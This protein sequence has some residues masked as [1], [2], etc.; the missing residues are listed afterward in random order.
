MRITNLPTLAAS[1]ALAFLLTPAPAVGQSRSDD[2]D[3]DRERR[4]SRTQS[5][6]TRAIVRAIEEAYKAP[7]EVHEEVLDELRDQ[8]RR[9]SS[10]REEEIIE[11]VRRM[12]RTTP[13][14]EEEILRELRTAYQLRSPKGEERVFAVIRK[15]K[16]MPPGT[17]HPVVRAELTERTFRRADR[18]DD[19][20]V[21]YDEMSEIL[22]GQWVRWDRN[23]DWAIDGEE[24]GRFFRAHHKEVSTAV[25][26]GK[27]SL[28]LPKGVAGP[29]GKSPT[30]WFAEY[31]TDGDGQVGLY[32]WRRMEQPIEEFVPMDGNGDG[33]LTARELLSY[34]EETRPPAEAKK[35]P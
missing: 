12:Y 7:L 15:N 30:G 19:E 9:P 6:E 14:T 16:L 26:A 5:A 13:E 24:Y 20:R 1:A 3:D 34:L 31:D 27:I 29:G 28:R 18:D 11:E 17:V 8:Y 4:T 23:L 35:A 2:D 33:Y 25:A 32:E 22:R 21:E 10:S